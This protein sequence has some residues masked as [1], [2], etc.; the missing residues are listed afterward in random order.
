MRVH[1]TP[2]GTTSCE[3]LHKETTLMTVIA[4]LLAHHMDRGK[5]AAVLSCSGLAVIR[6]P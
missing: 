4:E 5:G 1:I 2:R 3:K 6:L